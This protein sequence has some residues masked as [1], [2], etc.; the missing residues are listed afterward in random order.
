VKVWVKKPFYA[1]RISQDMLESLRGVRN[2][3]IFR[4]K[5]FREFPSSVS[6]GNRI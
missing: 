3:V 4:K 5:N 6:A 1:P 2:D